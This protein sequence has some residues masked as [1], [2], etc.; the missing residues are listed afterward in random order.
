MVGQAR[1]PVTADSPDS[2][3]ALASDHIKGQRGERQR[4]STRIVPRNTCTS[5]LDKYLTYLVED[6]RYIARLTAGK[7]FR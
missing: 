4:G 7:Y 1:S 3:P 5:Y 2:T 6:G